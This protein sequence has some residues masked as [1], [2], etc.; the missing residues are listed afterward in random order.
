MPDE[1]SVAELVEEV[2]AYVKSGEAGTNY[3][4]DLMRRVLKS[5]AAQGAGR[6]T[7]ADMARANLQ[8][9][10][11]HDLLLRLRKCG[12]LLGEASSAH[13]PPKAVGHAAGQ[14]AGVISDVIAFF[15]QF[16]PILQPSAQGAGRR[17]EVARVIDPHS[18]ILYS[19]DYWPAGDRIRGRERVRAKSLAKADQIIALFTSP[20]KTGEAWLKEDILEIIQPMMWSPASGPV[21]WTDE[22]IAKMKEQT[23]HAA[24]SLCDLFTTS[25]RPPERTPERSDSSA[26]GESAPKEGSPPNKIIAGLED[27]VNGRIARETVVHVGSP[28]ELPASKVGWK[29]VPIEPTYDQMLAGSRAWHVYTYESA[30]YRSP[31][32][33]EIATWSWVGRDDDNARAAYEAM[34]AAAPSPTP[35]EGGYQTYENPL[36]DHEVDR[37]QGLPEEG[38]YS[39]EV[40]EAM[41]KAHWNCRCPTVMPWDVLSEASRESSRR[42][43]RAALAASRP[44]GGV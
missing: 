21:V 37:F 33:A 44:T 39:D 13:T 3:S 16:E 4:R 20:A 35:E 40:V 22:T 12:S 36:N 27:A 31:T 30:R 42:D 6:L 8:G 9:R 18:W 34:L 2:S 1:Q 14:I 17:E 10:E 11:I 41:A 28:P 26:S 25:T 24:D 7:V 32:E 15:R 23:S 38:G 5:L 29:L 43:M 19:D